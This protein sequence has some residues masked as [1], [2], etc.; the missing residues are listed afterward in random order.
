MQSVRFPDDKGPSYKL[1]GE[2]REPSARGK[3]GIRLKRGKGKWFSIGK[4]KLRGGVF[5]K[6]FTLHRTG[7]YRVR[8]TFKGGATTAPGTIVQKIRIT[9]RVYF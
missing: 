9:R 3:V 2:L 7:N 8:Y 6:R 4:A 1:R 5:K